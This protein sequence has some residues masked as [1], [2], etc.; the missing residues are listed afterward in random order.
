VASGFAAIQFS[1]HEV[2]SVD[3][4][5]QNCSDWT[6]TTPPW[7]VFKLANGLA[8]LL[9]RLRDAITPPPIRALQQVYSY[10]RTQ[11]RTQLLRLTE[12]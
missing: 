6:A 8:A 4:Y 1:E 7:V 5:L 3:A 10:T 9:D 2:S 12:P 11:A